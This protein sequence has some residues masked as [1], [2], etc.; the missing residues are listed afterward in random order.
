MCAAG[1]GGLPGPVARPIAGNRPKFHRFPVDDS[2]LGDPGM[3]ARR[4]QRSR[5]PS[6]LRFSAAG[7][8]GRGRLSP[9]ARSRRVRDA[10]ASRQRG[11]VERRM[12]VD[13]AALVVE[14]GRVGGR[15]GGGS[16]REACAGSSRRRQIVFR[17][18]DLA[19]CQGRRGPRS[20]VLGFELLQ[21]E[22]HRGPGG[23]SCTDGT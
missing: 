11:V 20:G 5:S 8:P 3:C 2:A 23:G 15:A 19:Q 1:G 21:V 4:L 13:G 12:V 7:H 18:G 9:S 22:R 10:P 17:A 14:A 16:L 6:A